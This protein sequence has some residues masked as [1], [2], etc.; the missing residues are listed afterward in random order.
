[1]RTLKHLWQGLVQRFKR[2]ASQ[3]AGDLER[4]LVAAQQERRELLAQVTGLKDEVD[5]ELAS[6]RG[7]RQSLAGQLDERLDRFEH[8]LSTT[9]GELQTLRGELPGLRTEIEHELAAARQQQQDLREQLTGLQADFERERTAAKLEKQTLRGQIGGLQDDLAQLRSRD[10]QLREELQQRFDHLQ[11]EHDNARRQLEALRATLADER[12]RRETTEARA[13]T[14]EL[15]LKEQ[16]Q[17]HLAAMEEVQV[18]ERRQARRLSAAM[19]VAVA[20]FVLGIAGSVTN[21]WEVRDT[22]RLLAEVSQGIRDI[23]KALEGHSGADAQ[24]PAKT[25]ADGP[26]SEPAQAKPPISAPAPRDRGAPGVDEAHQ[27]LSAQTLPEPAFIAAGSLPL[28]GYAFR[29]R[30][31]LR[32]FFEENARQQGVVGLPGG[33]QYRVLIAGT[34]K[35]PRAGD[36]VTI[37]YRAFRP[38]GTELDNSIKEDLPTT[39]TVNEAIPALKEALPLMREGAQWELYIPPELAYKGVRKPG[40]HSFE[41]LILTLELLSVANPGADHGP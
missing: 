16:R 9:T 12:A 37:E 34:G 29:N 24:T 39:F 4:E 36:K 22:S 23:R 10:E 13:N 1:V 26:V 15:Q 6:A 5:R 14:L 18:R 19:T 21:F 38:D 11:G 8:D 30:Q 3:H 20:A 41:P 28:K 31:D 7:E 35:S 32:A 17:E 33:V 2:C 27:G 25:T 40:A